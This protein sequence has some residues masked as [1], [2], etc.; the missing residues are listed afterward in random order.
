MRRGAAVG[1]RFEAVLA[2]VVAGPRDAVEHDVLVERPPVAM[3]SSWW[4][5][6]TPTIGSPRLSAR[7]APRDRSGPRQIGVAAQRARASP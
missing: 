5:R 4:P 2:V 7:G 1:E 6:Q 3:F